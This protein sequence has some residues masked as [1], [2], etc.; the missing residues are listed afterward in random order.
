MGIELIEITE[1]GIVTKSAENNRRE[2][3]DLIGEITKSIV[4]LYAAKGYLPPW[5]DYLAM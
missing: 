5:I 1:K 2:I 4:E 3:E